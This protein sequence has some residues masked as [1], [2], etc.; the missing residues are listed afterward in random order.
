[1][2]KKNTARPVSAGRVMPWL[3]CALASLPLAVLLY[4]LPHY[5]FT[6]PY[7]DEWYVA[8]LIDRAQ[9]G[10]LLF[11]DYWVQHNEHRPLFPRLLMVGMALLTRWNVAW[12]LAA[13][14]LFAFGCFVLLAWLGLRQADSA[15]RPW[16]LAPVFSFFVFSWGQMEN[17]V[18]GWQI[19]WFMGGLCVVG[20]IVLLAGG[21]PQWPALIVAILL[22]G[23]ASYSMANGLLYWFAAL[24]VVLWGRTPAPGAD[25]RAERQRLW[26]RLLFWAAA[27]VLV[28]QTYLIDYKKPE[29]S[30]SFS[31]LWTSPLV[32]SKY[33]LLYLG[34]PVAA[35]FYPPIWHGPDPAP[36]VWPQYVPGLL[37]CVGF[38]LLFV[39]LFRKGGRVR[40]EL[41]PWLSLAAYA[42]GGALLTGMGRAGFGAAH[43]LTSRYIGVSLLFWCALAGL[44]ALYLREKVEGTSCRVKKA[45]SPFNYCEIVRY[46]VCTAAVAG[47]TFGAAH[48]NRNWEDIA[49]WKRFGWEAICY[50][51]EDPMYLQDLCWD[52][53][54]LRQDFLPIMKIHHLSGIGAPRNPARASAYVVEVAGFL[55]RHQYQPALVYLK[56][57]EYLEPDYPGLSDLRQQVQEELKRV[58]P[59]K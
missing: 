51:F 56:T 34:S 20:G 13:N 1:M 7:W 30:P 43:G 9:S 45:G 33:V 38:V 27:A 31:I 49:R 10:Q 54:P 58:R 25:T 24:P 53:Q 59:E 36:A 52:P 23:V 3:Y 46:A 16:W 39:G 40:Y 44:G 37:G 41:T 12:E 2:T 6:F 5:G 18:W 15:R 8:S 29:V 17:W 47:A 57:A 55:K 26:L 32:F 42:I 21:L 50:G 19:E 14:V 28:F 11:H 35:I 4:K 48:Q 22:G